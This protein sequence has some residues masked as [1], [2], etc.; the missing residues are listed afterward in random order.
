ML[1]V[2]KHGRGKR[3][4]TCLVLEPRASGVMSLQHV[5]M[6]EYVGCAWEWMMQA[7]WYVPCAQAA[8]IRCREFAACVSVSICWL[9]TSMDEA[10]ALVRAL[11]SSRVHWVS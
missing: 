1:A 8:C 7:S 9:C 4:G 11:C 3:L 10:S 6:F 5:S 2:R